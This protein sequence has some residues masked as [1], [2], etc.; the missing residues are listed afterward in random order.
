MTNIDNG[1]KNIKHG[2]PLN[3]FMYKD[4]YYFIYKKDY[5]KFSF[6]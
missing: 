3:E 2:R 5:T 6:D 4:I 1:D